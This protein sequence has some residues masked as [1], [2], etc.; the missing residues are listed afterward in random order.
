[1]LETG[2][3]ADEEKPQL[4]TAIASKIVKYLTMF[5]FFFSLLGVLMVRTDSQCVC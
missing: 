5:V 4:A 2:A 1:V 3:K